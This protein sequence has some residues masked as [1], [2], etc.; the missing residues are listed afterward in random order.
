MTVRKAKIFPALVACFLVATLGSLPVRAD[1]SNDLKAARG[2]LAALQA[3]LDR[4]AAQYAAAQSHLARTQDQTTQVRARIQRVQGRMGQIQDAL[5][6]RARVAYESGGFSTIELLLSADSFSTFSDGVE[7]LGSVAQADSDLLVQAS[8]TGEELRRAQDELAALSST[9]AAIVR[10][11]KSQQ[12][13]IAADEKAAQGLVS[14]L[15]VQL[16]RER[17][18]AAARAKALAEA[19]ARRVGGGPLEACPVGQPRTFYDD[20]GDPRPGGRTHQGIDMLAPLDTPIYAAQSGTFQQNYNDLGGNAAYVYAKNGD[21][22]YYAHMDK[23]AGVGDGAFVTAG[24]QIGYVG[25]T[26]DAQGGPYHLHF[27]YHPG[28]G[29]AVDPYKQLVAICG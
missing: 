14:K 13:A 29:S 26:G 10:S 5:S 12:A 15:S 21:Y 19:E 7:Y 9:Q 8:V 1:T 2:R 22:T 24:T 25:N 20:F 27:E 16:A 3:N 18:A 6:A 11:L 28:G 17:A 4:L 23:Y